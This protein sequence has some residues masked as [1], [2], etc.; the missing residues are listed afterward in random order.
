[1]HDSTI[2]IKFECKSMI[3]RIHCYWIFWRT[4]SVNDTTMVRLFAVCPNYNA[5]K[6][7]QM[8]I[9]QLVEILIDLRYI[10][11]SYNKL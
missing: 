10:L 2:K 6:I 3:L 11:I 1:M 9:I 5:F 8:Y 4:I 7:Q